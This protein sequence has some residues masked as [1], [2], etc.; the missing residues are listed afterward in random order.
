MS[1]VHVNRQLN[2]V[3]S[4]SSEFQRICHIF[5]INVDEN[6]HGL[7][8]QLQYRHDLL[9]CCGCLLWLWCE[10]KLMLVLVKLTCWTQRHLFILCMGHPVCLSWPRGVGRGLSGWKH[11]GTVEYSMSC[12]V[13]RGC[14]GCFLRQTQGPQAVTSHFCLSALNKTNRK[15]WWKGNIFS[16]YCHITSLLMQR[17]KA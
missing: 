3:I 11:H 6:I 10:W 9:T 17:N 2:E 14:Y 8:F 15:S 4:D 16:L 5:Y 12:T 13:T 7:S 1:C